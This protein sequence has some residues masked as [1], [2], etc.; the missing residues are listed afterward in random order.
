MRG[1][2][3]V[4]YWLYD[5]PRIVCSVRLH[6]GATD[7]EVRGEALYWH[8]RCPTVYADFPAVVPYEQAR[9]IVSADVRRFE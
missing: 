4:T 1:L 6:S 2:E 5:G 7:D 9:R 8:G 3:R